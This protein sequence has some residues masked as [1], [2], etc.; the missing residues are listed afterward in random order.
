MDDAA[1]PP[2]SVPDSEAQTIE[3]GVGHRPA[4][5]RH[6][7]FPASI[8]RYRIIQ[9][10]GEGGMGTVYEAEEEHPRRKVALKVIKPGATNPMTLRRFEQESEA[11]GRLHHPG[12]AQIYLA[13][14]D[15]RGYGPQ[16][17][18]AMEFIEGESLL[19]HAMTAKLPTKRRLELM[20]EVCDA[21]HH[22]HQR[23]IIHRDL[24]PSN[25]VVD[26][27]EHPKVLDF[28]LARLVDKETQATLHTN[29]GQLVGTLA[30]MSPEQLGGDPHD[31]DT[32]S[33]VYQLG[34][35]LYQLLA[36]KLPYKSDGTLHEAVEAID[37]HEPPPL[38]SLDRAYRG[39]IETIVAKALEKDKSRRYTSAAAM[40]ADIRRYLKDEP[41]IAR[42]PSATYQLH[43]F[44]RRHTALVVGVVA[45]FVVLVGGIVA[46]AWQ[47]TRARRAERAAL[48]D[49]DR[50]A[51]AQ[52][53]ANSVNDFLQN[54]LLAQASASNQARPDNTPD[55][56][57]KV[58]TALDRAAARIAGKFD[59]QPLVEAAIRQTI[60]K[61]YQDLGLYPEAETHL[62]RALELQRQVLGDG[63]ATVSATMN[64][65]ATLYATEGKFDQSEQ[66]F[67]KALAADRAGLGEQ[68][69][70][71]LTTTR[72]L[73]MLYMLQGKLP[74]AEPLL[75]ASL[76]GRRR[77]LG[78]Q[79]PDTLESMDSVASLY[80]RQGK[81]AEAEPI[82]ATLLDLQRRVLGEEHPQTLTS[83]NNLA[84]LSSYQ[85]KY[86]QA[87]MLFLD[88][89]EKMRRVLGEQ[90]IETMISI[91]NLGIVYFRQN[92]YPEAE[93][94]FTKALELKQRVLGD[95][96]PETLTSMNNLAVFY[97]AAGK[98]DLSEA[99]YRKVVDV[100]RRVVGEEH[101]NVLLTMNGLAYLFSLQG[102]NAQAEDLYLR[103]L[104]TQRRVLGNEHPDVA[105][106][107]QN[108]A[109]LYVNENRNAEAEPLA[110]E[111]MDI[112]RRVL[113][114]QHADTLR[115][116]SAEGRI[117][118]NSGRPADAES[119]LRTAL[120]TYE[121]TKADGWDRYNCQSLLGASLAAQ[122]QYADAE[123]LLVSAYSALKE[124][125]ASIPRE[126]RVA[127][128][129]AA[130]RVVQLYTAWGK[131]RQAA[132]WRRKLPPSS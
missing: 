58:R 104:K 123:P 5:V 46:S 30:Y 116:M 84:L 125:E 118:L 103:A 131:T 86:A 80:W 49:R 26:S 1:V 99:M 85:G 89:I 95:Q 78:E 82:R 126:N 12:I 32:R 60:G 75:V 7:Q 92:R 13:A 109:T 117:L 73:G 55:P 4:I 77:M 39:D 19:Q 34:V 65:I 24:K 121:S 61:T 18:F 53:I 90:H 51:E 68:H 22:A 93:A 52:A 14:T 87:E 119:L 110:R 111:A 64:S 120:A 124:R 106:T 29:V 50:A 74:E 42:P 132:E 6:S 105:T 113:G 15:D 41:I 31:V 20:A 129:R 127:V 57:L 33:D 2:S 21:V 81:Y 72:G 97:R 83:M 76:E 48:L 40:G 114:E 98:Y 10:L 112:R 38:G 71:T 28:G 35:I 69:A 27:E 9:V 47:A 102:K 63:H 16:P 128:E 96:H 56:D 101:P 62:A 54:D 70:Q 91:G 107:A 11:L 79:H 43:K 45:V 3:T 59:K 94:Q 88:V 8:G 122:T 130:A 17:Y 37:R 100:Q 36:G 115:S 25:I 44:A 23:G 108:L 66:L 67:T